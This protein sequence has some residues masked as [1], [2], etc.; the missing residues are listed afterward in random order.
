[1]GQQIESSLWPAFAILP[2]T[3]TAASIVSAS[4]SPWPL[5]CSVVLIRT[6]LRAPGCQETACT[7]ASRPHSDGKSG[8]H[9]LAPMW[10]LTEAHLHSTHHVCMTADACSCMWHEGPSLHSGTHIWQQAFSC[11]LHHCEVPPTAPAMFWAADIDVSCL[12]REGLPHHP[13]IHPW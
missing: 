5:Q 1:M 3:C 7:G 8:S 13:G 11:S 9:C 10:P 2:D 4:A 12:Q 6:C